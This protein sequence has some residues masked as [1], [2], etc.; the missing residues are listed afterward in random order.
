MPTPA[1]TKPE[2]LL[3]G[4]EAEDRVLN[5]LREMNRPFGA[6]D[7]SANIKGAVS[8]P[9]TQ[10]ILVAAAERGEITQKTY[11]KSTFFV[12]NQATME[13]MPPA[14]IQEL[15]A[16]LGDLTDK[17]KELT[18]QSK[19]L[20]QELV[21]VKSTPTNSDLATSIASTK[22][23]IEEAQAQVAPLRKGGAIV[24]EEEL[25]K[26]ETDWKK[27]R[28]EWISRK[29]V[30]RELWNTFTDAIVPSEAADLKENLGIEFDSEEHVQLE[31]LLGPG[32]LTSFRREK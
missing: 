28:G 16:E 3:K 26:M 14:K 10:K 15:T 17:N 6:V 20:Q 21:K 31:K 32:S 7:I 22:A 23:Q 24:S 12:T 25:A 5:Y 9:A 29:K 11:G 8:K 27:Y 2:K 19:T 1:T 30:F 4:K 13:D 18:V